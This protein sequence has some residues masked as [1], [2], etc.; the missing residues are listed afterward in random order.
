MTSS[1][2]LSPS[3]DS[4]LQLQEGIEIVQERNC[5]CEA[6]RRESEWELDEAD[7]TRMRLSSQQREYTPY[8]LLAHTEINRTI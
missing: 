4:A 6:E 7:T 3:L 8:T 1:T 5:M 2:S